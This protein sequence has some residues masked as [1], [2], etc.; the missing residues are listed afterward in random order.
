[1]KFIH[2]FVLS[3][4]LLLSSLVAAEEA[5]VFDWKH[6]PPP[7]LKIGD[8]VFRKGRGI[9]TKYFIGA[10]SRDP[11]FS[12]VGIVV[13]TMPSTLI[14]HSDGNDL[15]GVGQ[16]RTE[17]WP[18]FFEI[19]SECAVY[20]YTGPEKTAHAFANH[21]LLRLGVPFDP[22]FDMSSTN[23]LY[24]T[25]LIREVVNEAAGTNVIGFTVLKGQRIIA[26]DDIYHNGFKKVFDSSDGLRPPEQR[27]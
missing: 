10:S 19:A 13:R 22:S 16:V 14:L 25:E 23:A 8:L 9:W 12:H 6:T 15:T 4:Q 20:R 27:R 24:C 7:D 18:D 11:R 26:L 17:D 1:M 21:G 2:G 5:V 3:I